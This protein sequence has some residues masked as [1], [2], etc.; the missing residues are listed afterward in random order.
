MIPLTTPLPAPPRV[1]FWVPVKVVVAVLKV[2][3]D[4]KSE[5]T[6]EA[7]LSVTA[8]CQTLLPLTLS[9]APL[10]L[11]PVLLSVRGFAPTVLLLA[12]CRVPPETTVAVP[13]VARPAR[14]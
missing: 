9:S 3:V 7:A 11:V 4:P 1:R 2:R 8:P 13:A 14:P 12:G 6:R 5:L 10:L